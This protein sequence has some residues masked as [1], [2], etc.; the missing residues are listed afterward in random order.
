TEGSL[1]W[2]RKRIIGF[3]I[4]GFSFFIA[5]ALLYHDPAK[6]RKGGKMKNPAGARGALLTV[7][8]RPFFRS[9]VELLLF[10]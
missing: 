8:A 4:T 9:I 10:S 2:S 7:L 5:D 3:R 6:R 1:P